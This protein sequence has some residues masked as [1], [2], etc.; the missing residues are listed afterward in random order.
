[1]DLEHDNIFARLVF[2]PEASH[3]A[4]GTHPR[5][6]RLNDAKIQFSEIFDPASN[7][8]STYGTKILNLRR[9]TT[10]VF[11][12]A[13]K[14]VQHA[15]LVQRLLLDE[16]ALSPKLLEVNILYGDINRNNQSLDISQVG[17]MTFTIQQDIPSSFVKTAPS[18]GLVGEFLR[19]FYG[20]SV[21][22]CLRSR[23]SRWEIV[24][25]CHPL[26]ASMRN[27][28]WI[29]RDPRASG[30]ADISQGWLC[31]YGQHPCEILVRRVASSDEGA[32][33]CGPLVSSNI[34]G[35]MLTD[36]EHR[37]MMKFVVWT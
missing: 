20:P 4:D 6:V 5:I 2:D 34:A 23:F 35:D 29:F 15:G 37:V 3:E 9:S 19:T 28:P 32:H 10:I 24:E 30:S 22:A 14:L 12:N 7:S 27:Y 17:A 13:A 21:F 1:M 26:N 16:L 36:P 31:L 11:D 25:V 8:W 18:P 33:I